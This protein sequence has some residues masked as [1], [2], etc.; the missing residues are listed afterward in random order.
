MLTNITTVIIGL[1]ILAGVW[2]GWTKFESWRGNVLSVCTADAMQCPDGSY[3]GRVA[4][5]CEFAACPVAGT[6]ENPPAIGTV[7]NFETC[8]SLGYPIMESYPRQCRTP[9]GE[10]F[11]EDIVIS[12][13][14]LEPL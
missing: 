12:D 1:I 13:D 5:R 14:S 4:P 3:V 9:D 10:T 6:T 8:A 2:V 7:I 11:V